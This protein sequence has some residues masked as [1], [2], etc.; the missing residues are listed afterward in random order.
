MKNLREFE[1]KSLD[2]VMAGITIKLEFSNLF[3]G[4]PKN[5]DARI[6]VSKL[7]SDKN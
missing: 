7:N 3:D 2:Q 1:L 5:D 6:E 4:N